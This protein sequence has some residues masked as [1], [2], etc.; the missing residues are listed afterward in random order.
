MYSHRSRGRW[1]A[2]FFEMIKECNRKSKH[3]ND[4]KISH[5][6]GGDGL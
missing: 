1:T 3:W 4:Y 2:F 5:R 6:M